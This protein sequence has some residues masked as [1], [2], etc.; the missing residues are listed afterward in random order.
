MCGI[1]GYVGTAG[2]TL[3]VTAKGLKNLELNSQPNRLRRSESGTLA[4]RPWRAD[5]RERPSH[6]DEDGQVAIVHNGIIDNFDELQ[7][8]LRDPGHTF[9]SE[10][11]TEVIVHLIEEELE[12]ASLCTSVERV[13]KRL[14]GSFAIAVTAIGYDELTVARRGSPLVVGYG[15]SA[16]FVGSDVPAF[17]DHTRDVSFL[18][19]G[20]VAKITASD[21]EVQNGGKEVNRSIRTVDRE[22][23]AAEKCGN[24]HFMLK[25]FHE[26]PQS[27]RQT[28]SGRTDVING[29]VDLDVDL[30][31][32][33][34][35]S[36]EEIQIVAC[37][38]SYHASLYATTLLEEYAGVRANS[39][40]AS[41]YSFT[42]DRDPMDT[43][44]VAV[45][46]SG[47]PQTPSRRSGTP[48]PV[49]RERWA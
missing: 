16:N 39:V 40:L 2:K 5:R 38:A 3:P 19:D 7:A 47:E 35:H 28:V 26:Q 32:E 10:T 37:G 20:D 48:Q 6:T 21:V 46:Q 14:A 17:V 49:A 13:V 44:V 9:R 29:V 15:D 4:S 23:R 31:G 12:S 43:L 33:Y 1:I 22:P 8:E 42:G 36:L 27:L 18:E 11:D 24:G 30:T 34:L 45:T 25:E 41:E